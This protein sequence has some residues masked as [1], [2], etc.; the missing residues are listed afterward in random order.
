MKQAK[1]PVPTNVLDGLEAVRL[2]GKTNM[3]DATRVI[4]LAFEMEHYA[5]A[6]W[7]YENRRRYVEGIF[8][9]FEPVDNH[10]RGFRA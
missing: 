9:G 7:V 5:T 10:D 4:E 2:S 3:F 6:L 1:V 8:I